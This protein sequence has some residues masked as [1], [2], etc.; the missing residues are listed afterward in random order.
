M[1]I[2]YVVVAGNKDKDGQI[3]FVQSLGCYDNAEQAYGKAY[4]HLCELDSIGIKSAIGLEGETG[5]EIIGEVED[6]SFARFAW[7]LFDERGNKNE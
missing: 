4:M 2:K 6:G 7:V 5:F 1:M 3:E